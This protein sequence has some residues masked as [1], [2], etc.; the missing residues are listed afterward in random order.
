MIEKIQNEDIS[1]LGFHLSEQDDSLLFEGFNN[2]AYQQRLF[3]LKYRFINANGYREA[4]IPLLEEDV[5]DDVL[6]KIEQW[7]SKSKLADPTTSSVVAQTR[8]ELERRKRQSAVIT[9]KK[10]QVVAK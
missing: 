10:S 4:P 9:G 7:I 3:L 5:P 1:S 6:Q 8:E 2:I